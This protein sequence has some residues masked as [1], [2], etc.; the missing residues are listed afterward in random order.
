V[1]RLAAVQGTHAALAPCPAATSSNLYMEL[2]PG[3]L[4]ASRIAR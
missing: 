4:A 2:E 3:L 1:L